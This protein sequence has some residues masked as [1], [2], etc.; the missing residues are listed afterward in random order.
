MLND[1][2]DFLCK[3]GNFNEFDSF[4]FLI[5]I[6]DKPVQCLINYLINKFIIYI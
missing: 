1:E 2:I 3:E 6:S 4:E 5:F